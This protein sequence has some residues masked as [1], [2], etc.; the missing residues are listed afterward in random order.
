MPSL[1]PV[2]QLANEPPQLWK[3]QSQG[4]ILTIEDIPSRPACLLRI[5]GKTGALILIFNT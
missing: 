5:L 1:Q 4:D 3:W 2:L